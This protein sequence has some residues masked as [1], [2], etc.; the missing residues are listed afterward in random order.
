MSL[1]TAD[2]IHIVGAGPAGLSAAIAVARAGR[3]AVVFERREDVGT[4]F[5]GD[6]QGLENWTTRGDVLEEFGELGIEADFDYAPFRELVLFDPR[7]HEHLCRAARPLFYLVRRGSAPGTLDASLKVQAQMRGVEICFGRTPPPSAPGGV[8]SNGPSQSNII[9]VGYVFETEAA[10]GVYAVVSDRY[11]PKGYAYL[12]VHGGM[13][14]LAVCM[15]SGF[16][17]REQ[18]L[19]RT[20]HFFRER[21]GFSM[22]NSRRFGGLGYFG[23][24]ATAVHDRWLLAGEAAGFQ[25]ALF[26]FG[27][28]KAV[29]S[30]ALAGRAWGQGRPEDYDRLW[31]QR[32][33]GLLRASV[34]NR[35]LYALFGHLGYHWLARRVSGVD[36]SREWL[37]RFYRPS[38]AK[39]MFYPLS[40][41]F[42]RAV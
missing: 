40:R 6:Y 30:G 34:V 13:G 22:T 21:V 4:R 1:I 18:C 2:T 23:V 7:G 27:I 8:M 29:V 42:V 5:H 35:A 25:D 41:R 11:A 15:F 16:G 9:A 38:I 33:G 19:E 26:G 10:D 24:P 32:L 31:Q 20:L 37:R 12:L 14:T 39:D 17:Q 3:H 36:D 28:R